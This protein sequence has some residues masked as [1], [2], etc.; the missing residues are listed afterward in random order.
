MNI[1]ISAEF[2][3]RPDGELMGFS[4]TGHNGEAGRDIIC[5]SVSSAAYMTA[6]T[7]T[8]IMKA[9]AQVAVEDGYMLVRISPQEVK[10]CRSILAGFKLHLQELEEQYPQNIRVSYTEV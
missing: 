3:T 6:N 5:A 7:I 9:E 10:N 2:F 1:M 8:E 4:I